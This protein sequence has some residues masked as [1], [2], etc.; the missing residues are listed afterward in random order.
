MYSI[1][2]GDIVCVFY[3]HLL[4]FTYRKIEEW[5]G[6]WLF[7]TIWF[8]KKKLTKLAAA[9]C[10]CC[11][12]CSSFLFDWEDTCDEMTCCFD[13]GSVDTQF[14]SINEHAISFCRI[15][16]SLM[17]DESDD[18]ARLFVD[19]VRV[20]FLQQR[21]NMI[22]RCSADGTNYFFCSRNSFFF[23]SFPFLSLCMHMNVCRLRVSELADTIYDIRR[24]E[25]R[26]NLLTDAQ[27]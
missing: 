23:L 25:E 6:R 8:R 17:N 1:K 15:T 16:F 21:S 5:T 7:T 4:F 12:C 9:V 20:C 10:F 14:F 2:I 24:G 3:N 19:W 11:S 13:Q 26:T 22:V 18:G 27:N